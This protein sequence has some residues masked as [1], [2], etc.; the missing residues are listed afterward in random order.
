[1][2]RP[3]AENFRELRSHR[4]IDHTSRTHRIDAGADEE[5][6]I[7]FELGELGDQ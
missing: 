2:H 3:A 1:V 7:L 5:L 6:E 4:A